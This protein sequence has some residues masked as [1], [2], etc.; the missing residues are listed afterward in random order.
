MYGQETRV[1][2]LLGQTLLEGM[3]C[4]VPAICTSVA[5]MPEIVQNGINGFI[6][7]PNSPNALRDRISWLREHPIERRQMGAE[8]RRRVLERFTWPAVVRRCLNI[9]K[10]PATPDAGGID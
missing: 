8:A 6:V 7:P 9:Y 1:P 5:S 3:A 4:G 2:E 10:N